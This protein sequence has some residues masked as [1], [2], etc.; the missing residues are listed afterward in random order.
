MK[1]DDFVEKLLLYEL[2]S[3]AGFI[4]GFFQWEWL[5]DIIAGY[6]AYKVKRKLKRYKLRLKR[7]EILTDFLGR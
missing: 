7:K 2:P 3:G 5:T 1:D 4:A 6:L